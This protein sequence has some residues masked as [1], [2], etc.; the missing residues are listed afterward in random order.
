MTTK[1]SQAVEQPT[2]TSFLRSLEPFFISLTDSSFHGDREQYFEN[3]K[4]ELDVTWRT[5]LAKKWKE[6]FDVRAHVTIRIFAPATKK[7]FFTLSAS[8]L[9]HVHAPAPLDPEHVQRFTESEV[10][11]I[12]WPYVREYATSV[13][14]RMHVPPAILPVT[15]SK[16]T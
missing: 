12:I 15:G 9:L 16:G 14:G 6:S 8:Y 3:Q 2:Y 1:K 5:E 4:H 11:L 7:D 13:F 10:R